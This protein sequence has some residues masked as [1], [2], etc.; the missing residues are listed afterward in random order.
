MIIQTFKVSLAFAVLSYTTQIHA[1]CER[2]FEF[3]IDTKTSVEL[4]GTK[5][6]QQSH[7]L[8]KGKLAL[9]S[10]TLN[11]ESNWWALQAHQVAAQ[12][13][14]E[15]TAIVQYEVPFAF[16]QAPNGEL[17]D[18]WFPSTLTQQHKAMLKGLAYYFQ[19]PRQFNLPLVKEYQDNL[20]RYQ[21]SFAVTPKEVSFTKQVYLS[22]N[23]PTIDE[24]KIVNSNHGFKPDGCWFNH[25]KGLDELIVSS[26]QGALNLN[27]IQA[28]EFNVID[29]NTLTLTN[30]PTELNE[31][32]LAQTSLDKSS[33]AQLRQRLLEL[34]K[35]D[36]AT[37]DAHRLM[38]QLKELDPV[39][40][41]ILP[42]F[43]HESLSIKA[44]SRLLQALGKL[45]THNSQ[46]LLVQIL[47]TFSSDPNIQFQSLR[48][49]AYGNS[50]LSQNAI[51]ALI[52]TMQEGLI[53][54]EVAL[55]TSFYLTVGSM[56]KGRSNKSQFQGLNNALTNIATE[57]QDTR[58]R[59]AVLGAMGNSGDAQ[60]VDLLA[61]FATH[62][63]SESQTIA[64]K[65]LG[66]IGQPEAKSLLIKLLDAPIHP[67]SK[68]HLLTAVGNYDLDNV[69]QNRV[70]HYVFESDQKV[71]QAALVALGQ[72]TSLSNETKASLQKQISEEQDRRTVQLIVNAITKPKR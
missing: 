29:P 41:E 16:K 66:R 62:P 22:L 11:G 63:Q 19:V 37:F 21:I 68:P 59:N 7:L 9:K 3:A 13:G 18:F 6:N 2:A 39:L 10:A 38:L 61:K 46:T 33:V 54:K 52:M 67:K 70:L 1:Y 57:T 15:S 71:K 12:N 65:A 28:Y 45:D 31:W 47:N 23:D 44:Q 4:N 36:L 40:H 32:R 25:S 43:G 17:L 8:L 35:S 27:S 5:Q 48:A 24:T 53:T 72:Q 58:K 20:G 55:E 64:I 51:D 60:H 34:I 30:L 69:T 14:Q 56:I 42:L 50:P 49:L 26:N